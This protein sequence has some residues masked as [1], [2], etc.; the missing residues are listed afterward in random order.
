[1]GHHH[2]HLLLL[3]LLPQPLG[4]PAC[5]CM[6]PAFCF[7]L[8]RRAFVLHEYDR[9]TTELWNIDNSGNVSHKVAMP[10]SSIFHGSIQG[11]VVF[12][13]TEDYTD[14]GSN[15]TYSEGALLST[16]VTQSGPSPRY[17]PGSLCAWCLHP[18]PRPIGLAGLSC[19]SSS[20]GGWGW[21]RGA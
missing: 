19:R 2:H 10:L 9:L 17:V 6:F 16:P 7:L 5:V 18:H 20:H 15:L 4:L 13:L 1:M 12:S 11:L 3:L 21:G 8:G 14:S